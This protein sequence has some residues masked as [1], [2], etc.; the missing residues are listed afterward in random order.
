MIALYMIPCR[1]LNDLQGVLAKCYRLRHHHLK[2]F[3][4]LNKSVS[5]FTW[6]SGC[7]ATAAV[8]NV[9]ALRTGSRKQNSHVQGGII[10][11]SLLFTFSRTTIRRRRRAAFVAFLCRCFIC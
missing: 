8:C 5:Y 3:K 7:A 9:V 4:W 10:Q 11:I 2:W 6:P 1:Q